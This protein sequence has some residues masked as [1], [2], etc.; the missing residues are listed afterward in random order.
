MCVFKKKINKRY[1]RIHAMLCE[2]QNEN[3]DERHEG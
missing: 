2:K 3:A 1:C